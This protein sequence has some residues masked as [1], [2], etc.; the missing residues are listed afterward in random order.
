VVVTLPIEEAKYR[1]YHAHRVARQFGYP[2]TFSI[3]PI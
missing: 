1:V 3:R 2:L